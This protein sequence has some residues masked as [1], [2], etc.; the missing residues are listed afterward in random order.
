MFSSFRTDITRLQTWKFESPKIH[1]GQH[2]THSNVGSSNGKGR[3]CDERVS[4]SLNNRSTLRI[5]VNHLVPIKHENPFVC[6]HLT[7]LMRDT[8]IGTDRASGDSG[9]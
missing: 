6:P 7:K 4:D 5:V 8:V 2:S 3:P 9:I 1:K